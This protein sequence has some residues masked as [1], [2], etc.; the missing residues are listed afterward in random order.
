MLDGFLPALVELLRLLLR[1]RRLEARIELPSR[2]DLFLAAPDTDREACEIRSAECRR[3]DDLR[4]IDRAL[5]DI[6]LELDRKSTR[7]N[8]SHS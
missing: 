7:L 2:L 4:T 1:H 6:S 5:E 8:S 3:L